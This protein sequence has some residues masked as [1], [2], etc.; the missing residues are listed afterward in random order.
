MTAV[1]WLPWLAC[2]AL[3]SPSSAQDP[4]LGIS[5]ELAVARKAR[6]ANVIYRLRFDLHAASDAVEGTADIRFDLP[7][8]T[9]GPSEVQTDLVLD[10]AGEWL[11]L[12]TLNG[13]PV[14]DR[15]RVIADHVVL[16]GDMLVPLEN[17]IEARF[18]SRI[19]ATGTPLTRYVDSSDGA[20]YLYTLLVPADAH[21]LFPC[22][23]QPDLR[24]EFRLTLTIPTDWVAIG[25]TDGDRE[26]E[27]D[28]LVRASELIDT[29][30]RAVCFA[31]TK[32]L[33]TY[34]FAFAAGPFEQIDDSLPAGIRPIETRPLRVS[35]RRSQ[36]RFAEIERLF[37]MHRNALARL[38]E[39]F[40]IP[41]P[42]GKLEF[43]LLPGFPYGGMEHAGAIFY[44]ESALVFEREPTEPEQVRRSTLIYHEV[45]HQWFG[46]L[47]TMRW[48]DDL[49]LKEGFA[50]FLSYRL[51]AEIE[52]DRQ[53]WLRFL[54]RVKQRAYAI[55][56][57]S[58]T[59]PIWQELANLA[60]A[61]SAYGPIV[62]NKAPAV[63]R[64]LEA[65]L[66]ADAFRA[67]SR[68]FVA[69]HAFD[70]ATWQ[71]LVASFRSA[72]GLKD[73]RWSDRW[74]L[75]KGLPTVRMEWSLDE[76]GTVRS[77]RLTQRGRSPD[78][79][80]WPL[81]F[82]VRV[83]DRDGTTNTFRASLDARDESFAALV[84]R[85]A[86]L[87][88]LMNADDVAYGVFLPDPRSREWLQHNACEIVDPLAR[89]AAISQLWQAVREV[90]MNPADMARTLLAAAEREE[91][92]DTHEW[93]LAR[94]STCLLRYIG[95]PEVADDLI[96][97][98]L[99]LSFAQLESPGVRSR[100]ILLDFLAGL[101]SG[102]RVQRLLR[103]VLD[104]AHGDWKLS[105]APRDRFRLAAA[106]LAA[107]DVD[108]V[109]RERREAAAGSDV[110]RWAFLAGAAHADTTIKSR[111]FDDYLRADGPPE[112]WVQD[113]L[114]NFH[115][116]GQ[117]ELTLPFLR[118]A[119]E[120]LERVKKTR[121]IFFMPAWIDAFVNG[122]S[123]PEALEIVQEWL[124]SRPD[125]D[126]D[127]R[128]KVLQSLDE[129]ER[130]VRIRRAKW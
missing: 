112:Q 13:R 129:L 113:S 62:Y 96:E 8:A 120:N 6:I 98:A 57:T 83:F 50:T 33:P 59:T 114:G 19:A 124:A 126:Q 52:P 125:L 49:W 95:D 105:L 36:R 121:K 81:S 7:A 42:F 127:I 84:G 86:P 12:E 41:Y 11:S 14:G 17:R 72:G 18:R 97:R 78:D 90:E 102:E 2:A 101:S 29:D 56:E 9:D 31:P 32:P 23:D 107:G 111:Y 77:C 92:P 122:H 103:E 40:G 37:E 110:G 79:K 61:K 119:M 64:E 26:P 16:P 88:V 46:N 108:A 104:G 99:D 109:E 130:A 65:R 115:W 85:P 76:F 44:R 34:L 47:V 68:R 35:L 128:S 71:D 93:L 66:G 54:Q 28:G 24:A 4:T 73:A 22:F 87:A 15:A 45:A 117:S 10:F 43:V 116:P 67:A 25:N 51:L 27:D 94:L 91:D 30:R 55:D 82:T 3:L 53:S 1:R 75:G 21:A 118:R 58:G 48:F 74:I 63:L 89:V 123:S 69:E 20:E 80:P 70:N 39:W 100:W 5:R 60:E 38:D 106:L